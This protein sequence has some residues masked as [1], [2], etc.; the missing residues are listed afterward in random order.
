VLS[1]FIEDSSPD[2]IIALRYIK[3]V[4]GKE[5]VVAFNNLGPDTTIGPNVTLR[6]FYFLNGGADLGLQHAG[7]N[8]KTPGCELI[9]FDQ[10]KIL[11]ANGT[12]TYFVSIRNANPTLACLHNLQG[13]GHV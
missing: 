1:E 7:A 5:E 10:S 13:G 12:T 8:I 6:W 3:T 9:N 4:L 2:A 11:N